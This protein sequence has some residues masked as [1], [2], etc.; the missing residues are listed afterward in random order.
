MSGEKRPAANSFGSSQLVKRAKADTEGSAL[1]V[2]NRAGENGALI[3]AQGRGGLQAPIMELQGH[4][5]EVFAARFDPTGQFIASGAMDRSILLWHSSGACENYGLLPGHKQAILDLHWSRDSKVLFSASADMTL[6]S[7][8]VETGERI[9]RHP[10]HEEVINC[11][12]VS[13]RGEEMLVSGSDDGYIG[14]WDPRTKEAVKFIETPFPITAIALSEAGNELFTGGIDN[15]I[16]VWDLRKE[17]VIYSL[18]GHTDTVT[19]LQLSPDNMTLLSN[20]HDSTVRTW[21]V[22]PFAPAD[23]RIRTYDG[24]PTG[25]ERNLFKASWDP[26]GRKIAAG[27]GDQTVAIWDAG[28]GKLLSKLPGHR[29]AVNDVRFSPAD[30]SLLLSASSDRTL[31]LGELGK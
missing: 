15:D 10:G 21:D 30:E 6:A 27:S 29:G 1:S 16:K 22:R 26:K 17:E 9:R 24:A 4:T 2:V 11:M 14:L 5:G 7:W 18:L 23:R 12:D 31:L 13:K 25:Q 28:S 20:A 19:S 3:Q 8:D